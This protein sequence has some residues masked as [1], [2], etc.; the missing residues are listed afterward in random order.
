MIN[1]VFSTTITSIKDISV[2]VVLLLLML[3]TIYSTRM[4]YHRNHQMYI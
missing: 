1:N 4:W 2:K 3:D